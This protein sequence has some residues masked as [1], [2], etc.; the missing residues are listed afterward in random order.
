MV[1]YTYWGMKKVQNDAKHW[2]KLSVWI[3]YRGLK[4][5]HSAIC[6]ATLNVELSLEKLKLG[7]LLIQKEVTLRVF[8]MMKEWYQVSDVL[9]SNC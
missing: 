8:S 4:L 6:S 1:L 5:D 2:Y 9:D 3:E 7:I